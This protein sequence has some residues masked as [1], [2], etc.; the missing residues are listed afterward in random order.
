MASETRR[1]QAEREAGEREVAI[2]IDHVSKRY[3]DQL[4]VNDVSF[5][6]AAGEIVGFLGPN[7]AGKSTLL[8]MMCTWLPPTSGRITIAGHDVV[9]EPLAMF[10][11]H[12]ALTGRTGDVVLGKKSGTASVTYHLEL[13][14]ITDPDGEA[15][16][17]ILGQVKALGIQKKG[18]VTEEEF[19]RIAESAGVLKTAAE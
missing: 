15:V 19:R 7:G 14:G 17:E 16:K 9:K 5:E 12:P 4:A 2:R 3:G 10:G 8:K 18:L 11:T 6:V 1:E 13:M